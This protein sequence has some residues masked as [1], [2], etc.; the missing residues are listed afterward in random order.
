MKALRA[1][2]LSLALLFSGSCAQAQERISVDDLKLRSDAGDKSATRALAEA[3]YLGRGGVEQD[4]QEA[5]RW[6]RRLATQGDAR[7]QTSLGLMYARGLGFAQNMAE[8]RRWWSLAA[9]QNDA[10]AQ[11]SL[12]VV[13]LEGQGVA[14]DLP[15]AFRWFQLAASRGHPNAQHNL[16]LMYFNGDGV[17]QDR[18]TGL[19]WLTV[20]AERG[21]DR[22]QDFLKSLAGRL[23]DDQLARA[24][25][26]ALEWIAKH[27]AWR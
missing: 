18:Q 23:P 11:Y 19:T 14:P 10:G 25:S 3:Y 12:G 21:E 27:P 22:A 20:A 17:T 2:V 5:A 7:A 8:A 24:R 13:Y 4:F 1:V 15:Q 16:G 9:A 26:Q 6:Y